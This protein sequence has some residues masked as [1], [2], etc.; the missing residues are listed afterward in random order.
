MSDIKRINELIQDNVLVHPSRSPYQNGKSSI[1]LNEGSQYAVTIHHVP[2][3]TIAFKADFFPDVRKFFKC[4]KKECKRADFVIIT[5]YDNSMGYIIFIEMKGGKGSSDIQ[6]QHQLRGAKCI[7]DYCR[8]LVNE[9]WNDSEF[10]DSDDY[11]Q[12]FVSIKDVRVNKKPT[13]ERSRH[14][15]NS[16]IHMLKIFSPGKKPIYFNE[17]IGKPR[18]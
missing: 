7:V 1:V 4:S 3:D 18:I 14:P 13:R 2:T 5:N 6:I 8:S 12:C 17:L 9:F 10:L 16:P 11:K 15:N